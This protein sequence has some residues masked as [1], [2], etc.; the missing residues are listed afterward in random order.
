MV[1]GCIAEEV[2][3]TFD[4]GEG[5]LESEGQ[6]WEGVSGRKGVRVHDDAQVYRLWRD[7]TGHTHLKSS[8]EV[9][10]AIRC[11]RSRRD[12]TH[13]TKNWREAEAISRGCSTDHEMQA[14]IWTA[15]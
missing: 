4:S 9:V 5:L 3:D 1:Y 13:A 11:A 15:V 8:F 7:G 14:C 10:Q 6:S 12:I 2:V